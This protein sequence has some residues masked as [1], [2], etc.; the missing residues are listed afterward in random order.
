MSRLFL[1]PAY[2]PERGGG[3]GGGGSILPSIGDSDEDGD[4]S[5][6]GVAA[7]RSTHMVLQPVRGVNPNGGGSA[8]S[9]PRVPVGG[10]V[11]VYR[12]A[13]LSAQSPVFGAVGNDAVYKPGA[14]TKLVLGGAPAV[15][16]AGG[17]SGMASN[18]FSAS[19]KAVGSSR[20]TIH[21]SQPVSFGCGAAV[22]G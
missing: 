22:A 10:G 4:F 12:G 8:G 14:L 1:P 2:D 19:G 6:V 21:M 3:G 17:A 15:D 9:T 7:L 20:I 11:P 5:G 16:D 18:G 13:T